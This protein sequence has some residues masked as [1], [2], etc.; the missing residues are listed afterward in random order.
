[1]RGEGLPPNSKILVV[2]SDI[3]WARGSDE[4]I[5]DVSEVKGV[6]AIG[7]VQWRGGSKFKTIAFEADAPGNPPILVC[8]MQHI[9]NP[10]QYTP[11]VHINETYNPHAKKRPV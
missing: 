6:D 5:D 11:M 4:A 7:K 9:K 1:M 3:T 8:N 2:P 10:T